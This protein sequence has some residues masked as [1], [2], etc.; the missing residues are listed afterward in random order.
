[1]IVIEYYC[2]NPK[3]DARDADGSNPI[4]VMRKLRRCPVCDARVIFVMRKELEEK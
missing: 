4:V 2:P 1:M 3:C